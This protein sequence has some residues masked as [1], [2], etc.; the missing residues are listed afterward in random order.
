MSVSGSIGYSVDEVPY[1]DLFIDADLI[2]SYDGYPG[3]SG[4]GWDDPGE[5]PQVDNY[6]IEDI[7]TLQITDEDGNEV[8]T[9]PEELPAIRAAIMKHLAGTDIDER[10]SDS[11]NESSDCDYDDY[12]CG[13]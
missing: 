8:S 7:E 2:I 6:E 3:S 4:N 13:C 10:I 1:G 12:R 11:I 9:Q 5:G